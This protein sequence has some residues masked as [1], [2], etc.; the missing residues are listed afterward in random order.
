M[1]LWGPAPGSNRMKAI[2]HPAKE[3]SASY[4]NIRRAVPS[5]QPAAISY[6]ISKVP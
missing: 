2:G 4:R 3:A 6:E 5:R 1:D